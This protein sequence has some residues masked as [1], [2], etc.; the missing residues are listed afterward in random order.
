M[1]EE[2][3]SRDG[4]WNRKFVFSWLANFFA[5]TTM[6]YLM[7]T[8]PL[9]TTQV[10][11]GD[12]GDV[13]TLFALFAFAGVVAR[14]IAGWVLDTHGRMRAAWL[15]LLLLLAAVLAYNWAAGLGALFA[16]RFLHGICWGFSTTSLATVAADVI[17]QR[18]RGEGIGYFGLS[19]SFAMLLGP[20][21]GLRLLQGWDYSGMFWAVAFIAALAVLCLSGIRY[22]EGGSGHPHRGGHPAKGG[23]PPQRGW[24]EKRV[25][26]YGAIVFFM[27]IGYGTVLSFIVLFAQEIQLD[28]PAIFFLVNAAGVI[29]SR[30]YAGRIMDKKGPVGIMC[31][32]FAAFLACF[33]CLY[34]AQ[35][36]IM[37]VLAALL[38]GIGF[39]ILYSLCFALAIN[40]VEKHRRGMANGT[41]LTAFD[42]GFAVG[43]MLLGQVSL[44]LGLRLMYLSC[45]IP[46]VLA[47]L[48]FYFHDMHGRPAD[49]PAELVQRT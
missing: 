33:L 49:R 37:F 20:W 36:W 6:Y 21:L 17:P 24:L 40:V 8:V 28:N 44:Y 41:I 42:L 25:L 46:A 2:M 34:L 29:V 39:G 12:K 1:G 31:A 9:Y 13:G 7:S 14:P 35:G 10:L 30:P 22:R 16:L 47:F 11:G 32:G 43:S 45:V 26:A 5:F 48:V 4:L 27:A 18:R 38:L 3:E 23:R 15:S 19:M